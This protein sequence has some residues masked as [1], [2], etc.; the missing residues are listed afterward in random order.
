MRI[1]VLITTLLCV[2]SGAACRSVGPYDGANVDTTESD[3]SG[4]ESETEDVADSR[5]ESETENVADTE[6]LRPYDCETED[7]T[8]CDSLVC[9]FK[10]TMEEIQERSSSYDP[11]LYEFTRTC[12]T[13]FD[14]CLREACPPGKE[15]SSWTVT[16]T[17]SSN[18]SICL[19][20]S[21]PQ[22][23]SSIPYQKFDLTPGPAPPY[24]RSPDY[25]C[26]EWYRFADSDGE[27]AGESEIDYDILQENDERKVCA[28]G[29]AA[30]EK[31]GQDAVYWGA[32][33]GGNLGHCDE[34]GDFEDMAD[35]F[36]GVTFDIEGY[37][38]TELRVLFHEFDYDDF[39]YDE[40]GYDQSAYIV[41]PPNAAHVT[42]LVD[43]ADVWYNPGNMVDVKH[44]DAIQFH[45]ATNPQE[46]TPFDFC[47]SGLYALFRDAPSDP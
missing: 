44:L 15:A 3:D 8:S 45:V 21:A 16:R 47:I 40:I 25:R 28:E 23:T 30:Q 41:V 29:I 32:G 13:T 34:I 39:D 18:L 1:G 24:W 17:C 4:E 37:W 35:R 22:G 6:Y 19:T 26:G 12:L 42:A 31:D 38:G 36:I 46:P 20:V 7:S 14:D 5:G 11:S 2:V 43:Q 27:G 9:G 33:F 10:E